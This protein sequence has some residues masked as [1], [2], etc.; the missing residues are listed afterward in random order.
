[1]C[2]SLA[3]F[4]LTRWATQQAGNPTQRQNENQRRPKKRDERA[5]PI[6]WILSFEPRIQQRF[7]LYFGGKL[8]IRRKSREAI[9]GVSVERKAVLGNG[10]MSSQMLV[11]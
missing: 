10:S 8:L 5:E 4:T 6:H 11:V 2:S 3:S 7:D 1:M 9:I